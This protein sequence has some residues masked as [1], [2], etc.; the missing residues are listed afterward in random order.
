MGKDHSGCD[1]NECLFCVTKFDKV[2]K[3]LYKFRFMVFDDEIY[4]V[5]IK[6]FA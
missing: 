1:S 2:K 4:E 5:I 3:L 6:L